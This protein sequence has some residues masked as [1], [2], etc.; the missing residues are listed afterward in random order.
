MPNLK[1]KKVGT[2]GDLGCFSLHP[3]KAI[4]TGEGGIV[5][6]NNDELAKELRVLRNHGIS[7]KDGKVDFIATGLNYI[8]TDFQAAL[9]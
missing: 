2:Y 8:M 3:R 7:Y 6:T 9:G 5:V 1:T 4:K